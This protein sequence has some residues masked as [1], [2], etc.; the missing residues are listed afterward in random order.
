M[1]AMGKRRCFYRHGGDASAVW[2]KMVQRLGTAL[3][4]ALAC[5]VALV[6]LLGSAMLGRFLS[7]SSID[8]DERHRA[9][10]LAMSPP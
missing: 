5:Q 1:S 4:A 6:E 8:A 9:W 2:A 7:Q 3:T 10:W